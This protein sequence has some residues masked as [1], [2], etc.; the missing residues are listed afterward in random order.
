MQ[1]TFLCVELIAFAVLIGVAFYGFNLLSELRK[2]QES[3]FAALRKEL[4]AIRQ[5][6]AASRPAP[7]AEKS[8]EPMAPAEAPREPSA[9]SEPAEPVFEE[10]VPSPLAPVLTAVD[11]VPAGEAPTATV[12]PPPRPAAPPPPR[13]PSPFELAAQNTLRKIWNWFIVGEEHIPPGVSV[14]YAVASQWLLRLGIVILV[15]GIGFFLKYSFDNNLIRPIG[16]VALAAIAGLAMLIAGTQILGRRYHVF[17]QGL[18]G[19]GLATLYFSVFAA[20]NFYELV[21][22]L[23]AFVLMGLIT[24]LAGGVAVRF[25]SMLV[26]VLGIIGGYGTP[27][28]LSTGA[29]D[30]VG[31]YGYMLVLGLGVLGICYWKNWPLVNLLSFLATYLLLFAS[32]R[33]YDRAHFWEVLPFL[34]AFFVLFSAMTILYNLVNRQRSNLLELLALWVNA[35]IY[36]GVSYRLVTDVYG[37]EWAAAVTLGLAAFYTAHVYWFLMRKLVDRELLVSFTGL[38]AFFL[39]VTMPLVLSREWVTVSW[40]LQAFV[41]LWIATQLG[42]RFLTHLSY[43]LYGI[44]MF[45]FLAIDLNV[46]FGRERVPAELPMAEYLPQLVERL[47]AF[48]VPVG[49]L[50]LAA[51]WLGRQPSEPRPVVESRNDIPEFVPG[52]WAAIGCVIAAAAL[53]F[54]Y[55]N[56]ELVRT[57]GYFYPPAKLMLMTL[58]WLAFCVVLLREALRSDSPALVGVLS[59]LIV[60][61]LVKLFAVDMMSW[62]L[63]ER[64][65][66]S[67]PYSFREA[68]FR[69]VDFG[70]VV[71]LLAAAYALFAGRERYQEAR[72]VFGWAALAVLFVYLTLELNT[73]LHQYLD[74]IRFGG[75]SILWSVFALGLLVWGIWRNR[76]ELRYTGLALFVIVAF[77]VF[78]VDLSQLDAFYRIIAFIILGMVVLAGSFLYLKYRETF[79]IDPPTDEAKG[80]A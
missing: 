33:A 8:P 10:A 36:F 39:A 61:V 68:T 70:A 23:P 5:D 6:F 65:L 26:A 52:S 13:Q 21:E 27:L 40:A 18:M 72:H 1:E 57:V 80:E 62:A 75:V 3:A 64:F 2:Q 78:L 51:W 19:G 29:V 35:G 20:A 42:S 7:A 16:R 12:S 76:R 56:F 30:F 55:L 34:T 79:A 59:V 24:V 4:R 44:V 53:L 11:R 67:G 17:G 41:M 25:H 32:L 74:G 14:E 66:Y 49:S 15:V 38:A 71:A 73:F 28:M 47:I 46:Q 63:T 9:A 77:K 22:T 54:L 60:A 45:R 48:G 43:V 31:L 37:K 69:L 50:A 58:M